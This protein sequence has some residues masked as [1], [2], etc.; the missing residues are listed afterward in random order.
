MIVDGENLDYTTIKSLSRLL[1]F[2][3]ESHNRTYSFYMNS[4]NGFY[5]DSTIE[6]H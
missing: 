5:T 4:M 2:L 6:N 3:N 1:Q